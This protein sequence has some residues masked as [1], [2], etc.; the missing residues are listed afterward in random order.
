[1]IREI[2]L[3]AQKILA[4]L[5]VPFSVVAD[6]ETTETATWGRERIV[7]GY[8]VDGTDSFVPAHQVHVNPKQRFAADEACI[9][10]IYAR[11]TQPGATVF[12]HRRRVKL[13]R[14]KLVWALFVVSRKRRN[15]FNPTSGRLFTPDDLKDTERDGGAAYELRFTFSRGMDN[16]TWA[17]AAAPEV[18]VGGAGG[19]PIVTRDVVVAREDGDP[20]ND[21]AAGDDTDRDL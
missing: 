21:P 13:A 1:M 14:D 12:E 5:G 6:K 17:G 15:R 3:E 10:R 20:T 18:T 19:I 4:D 8:D 16:R 2:A 9:A 7:I 11:S